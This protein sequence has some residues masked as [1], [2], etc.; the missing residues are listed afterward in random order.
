MLAAFAGWLDR[1]APLGCWTCA[2]LL[3]SIDALAVATF[4]TTRSRALVDK[5]TYPLVVANAL[6]LGTGAAVPAAMRMTSAAVMVV[7]PAGPSDA[8]PLV[9]VEAAQAP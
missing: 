4:A 3:V 7:A 9:G 5:W 1:A 2:A 6:L 8:M